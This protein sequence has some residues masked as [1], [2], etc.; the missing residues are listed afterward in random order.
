M[1]D[2]WTPPAS[3]PL[4]RSRD[5]PQDWQARHDGGEGMAT[6]IA[7]FST[8]SK[9]LERLLAR[10]ISHLTLGRGL[11]TLA[12]SAPCQSARQRTLRVLSPTMPAS[13]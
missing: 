4:G 6:N 10:R 3:L 12:S 11:S 7:L 2:T 1:P 5:D 13:S 8:L 9:G